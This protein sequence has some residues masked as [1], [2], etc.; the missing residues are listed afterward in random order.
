MGND[1]N[2]FIAMASDTIAGTYEFIDELGKQEFVELV[3][4]D[5][6]RSTAHYLS[7]PLYSELESITDLVSL[8]ANQPTT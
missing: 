1:T 7:D 4:K 2:E 8:V 5:T 6:G 3:L